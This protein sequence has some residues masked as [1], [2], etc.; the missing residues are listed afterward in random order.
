MERLA[1]ESLWTS[2][3]MQI[4]HI[5]NKNSDLRAI[6]IVMLQIGNFDTAHY[7]KI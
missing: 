3:Y 5:I 6:K 7:F 1:M 4:I 2:K